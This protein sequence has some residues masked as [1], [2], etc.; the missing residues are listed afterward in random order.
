MGNTTDLVLVTINNGAFLLC[1]LF[2]A[3]VILII[4]PFVRRKPAQR[5]DSDDFRWHFIIPCLN[6]EAVIDSTVRRLIADFPEAYVWCVDDGSTDATPELLAALAA[7]CKRVQ[8]VTRRLPDARQGKGPALNAGWQALNGCRPAYVDPAEVIVG[9][10]DADGQL[11]TRCLETIAGPAFFGDP[12]VGAVQIQVRVLDLP[13]RARRRFA[14][15]LV[16][17]QDVEFTVVIAA[18]QTLRRH[19]GSVGLGGNG[20]FTR[21]SALNTIAERHGTPWHGA[22]LE[23]FEL[24]LHVL[25][26][27]NR[28]EYCHDTWVSQ[29]GLPTLRTLIRQRSRWAQGAM[30]CTRYLR[31][32]L[33]SPGITNFGAAEISYFLLLPW[34]QLIGGVIYVVATVVVLFYALTAVGGPSQWF[35]A[36]GW[37][38]L[39]LF[40]LFGLGPL[41]VWGPV[42]RTT[43]ARGLSRTRAI[44]LGMANWPYSY[45]HHVATWWA[46]IRVL[47]SRH[48]WKKTEREADDRA[49]LLVLASAPAP[50]A[51]LPRLAPA[52]AP[53]QLVAEPTP[54]PPPRLTAG[55]IAPTDEDWDQ[56]VIHS[57]PADASE[58]LVSR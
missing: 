57:S 32:V 20:Q 56:A 51:P 4:V 23:D 18:M 17:L 48:D 30:Q 16:R 21:L 7:R 52:P 42:Y 28:T 34:M 41:V 35:Q 58:G 27:G 5:G 43:R 22:L 50:V 40:I 2:L 25:L 15:L 24:G 33:R 55:V 10:V 31:P 11:D 49:A 19:V 9:V 13:A 29:E 1:V 38:L 45:V 3:Y 6:E 14:R 47:R 39:P 8:V 44:A 36:D 12:G 54:A 26:V 37:G 53:A 46:F